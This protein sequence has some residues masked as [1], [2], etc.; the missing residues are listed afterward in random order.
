MLF[1][2]LPVSFT[3][4]MNL[5]TKST[6]RPTTTDK[7]LSLPLCHSTAKVSLVLK[8]AKL[9]SH[10]VLHAACRPHTSLDYAVDLLLDRCCS[11]F[12][13]VERAPLCDIQTLTRPVT[14]H[15]LQLLE[16]SVSVRNSRRP[17]FARSMHRH[18]LRTIFQTG[19]SIAAG[20]RALW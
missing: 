1:L 12:N 20:R 17:H 5:A 18:P 8:V 3:A 19:R 7:T 9:V 11:F 4:A 15:A 13:T 6:F 14:S 16:L 2:T 10:I